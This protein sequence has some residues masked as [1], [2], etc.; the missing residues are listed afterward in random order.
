MKGRAPLRRRECK[1]LA[2]GSGAEDGLRKDKTL[3]CPQREETWRRQCCQENRDSL[4]YTNP[5]TPA[6]RVSP[7]G[8]LIFRC[9]LR[10]LWITMTRGAGRAGFKVADQTAQSNPTSATQHI[11]GVTDEY[12]ISLCLCPLICEMGTVTSLLGGIQ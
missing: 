3:K 6:R 2:R 10:F 4:I 7:F 11:S 5:R 1:H 9:H 8:R 12:L